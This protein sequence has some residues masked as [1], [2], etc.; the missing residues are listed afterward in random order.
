[1]S[2]LAVDLPAPTPANANEKL[3]IEAAR[4]INELVIAE[5]RAEALPLST[6]HADSLRVFFGD[7]LAAVT[8]AS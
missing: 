5:A 7:C 1:M 8:P 4:A 6:T 2:N 3:R